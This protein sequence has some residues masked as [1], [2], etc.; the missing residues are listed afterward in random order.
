MT[1]YLYPGHGEGLKAVVHGV[2]FGV[3]AAIGGYSVAA[4][5]KR[6]ETHLAINAVLAVGI[7]WKEAGHVRDHLEERRRRRSDHDDAAT[8]PA[9]D[10]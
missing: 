3:F 4:W 6:R 8:R 10:L 9:P 5:L 7:C 1:R 2:A